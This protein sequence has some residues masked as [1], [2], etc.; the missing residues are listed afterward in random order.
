LS[1]IEYATGGLG[2]HA[3][4][5]QIEKSVGKTIDRIQF[6]PSPSGSR[7]E[8]HG[9]W[10]T[11]HFSDGSRLELETGSNAA[12][13]PNGVKASDVSL[14]FIGLFREHESSAE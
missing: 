9:E 5:S 11:L 6:G 1:K 7:H 3:V 13:L 2:P 14:S 12:Q 4:R 8:H 10:M